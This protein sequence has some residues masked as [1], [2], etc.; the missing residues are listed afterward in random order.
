MARPPKYKPI[1]R[2]TLAALLR[3][4]YSLAVIADRFQRSIQT[5][6]REAASY[7]LMPHRTAR[8]ASVT[9]AVV[10]SAVKCDTIDD[11]A[12]LT[13]IPRSTVHRHLTAHELKGH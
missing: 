8:A 1:G 12:A 5:V 3:S 2:A 11:I 9:R 10:A 13:G 4:G 6:S 7:D